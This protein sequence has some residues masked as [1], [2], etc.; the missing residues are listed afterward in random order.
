MDINL[1]IQKRPYLYHLTDSRNLPNILATGRL[2]STRAIL[3]ESDHDNVE[4]YLRTR[5]PDHNEITIN[6][7]TYHVRD[8]RPISEVVLSRSLTHNWTSGDFIAHLNSRVFFW[9]TVSRLERHFKRYEN[10]HPVIMRFNTAEML[11]V[12]TAE[13]CRLNSG[14]T[15][16][17]SHWDGNAPERGPDTFQIADLYP[18]NP[19]TVAEVTIPNI[20]ILP[21]DFWTSDNPQGVWTAN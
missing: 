15:R 4:G 2:F 21:E 6:G 18:G 11:E 20:C 13:F 7:F 1:F 10:E 14:A 17:S 9:P 12:N 5:R 19:A 16:C 3:E 8:Q